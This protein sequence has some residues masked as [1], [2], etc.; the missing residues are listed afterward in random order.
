MF[1]DNFVN[2]PNIMAR[3]DVIHIPT[4]WLPDIIKQDD[5]DN[6]SEWQT[7][8]L[9]N[10]YDVYMFNKARQMFMQDYVLDL[11]ESFNPPFGFHMEISN[12]SKIKQSFDDSL[13]CVSKP[14]TKLYE[15]KIKI[16]KGFLTDIKITNITDF[17]IEL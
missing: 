17:K 3:Y 13:V 15:I 5:W 8:E 2:K 14:S 10:E 9:N 6:V 1:V 11:V 4:E 7:K 12:T 16:V